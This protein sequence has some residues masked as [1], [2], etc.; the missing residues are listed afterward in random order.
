ME[1]PAGRVSYRNTYG[2]CF[3]V[4]EADPL[5]GCSI[6]IPGSYPRSLRVPVPNFNLAY[7]LVQEPGFPDRYDGVA[8]TAAFSGLCNPLP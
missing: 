1:V 7:H 6:A 5:D 4:P 2:D 3:E 8:K